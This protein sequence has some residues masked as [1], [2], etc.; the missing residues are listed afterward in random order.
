MKTILKDLK[1]FWVLDSRSNP[2]VEVWAWVE[3]NGK[4]FYDSFIVPSGASTGEFE[5]LELRDNTKDFHGKGVSKAINSVYFIRDHLINTFVDDLFLFD[6]KLIELDGSEN[7]SNLGANAIL[8]VS[9]SVAKALAKSYDLPFFKFLTLLTGIKDYFLPLPFMNVINGGVHADNDLDF[10]EFMICP[11]EFDTFSEA[12]KAGSEIYNTLKKI[13]KKDGFSVSVGDEGGFAPAF[14]DPFQACDYITKAIEESGYTNKVFLALDVAASSL[15]ENGKYKYKNSYIT[16]NDLMNIYEELINRYP[17]ISIEDPFAE[18]DWQSWQNFTNKY[19]NEINIV[20]DDLFVTNIKRLSKGID[21]G[22]ANS[23]LIKLNQIGTLTETINT[24]LKALE[25]GFTCI[26]SH[27]SGETEDNT[28]S[29]IACNIGY[30]IKTGAPARSERNA[31]YNELRRI[32]E[33][34]NVPFIK[35]K[36]L[37]KFTKRL[38]KSFKN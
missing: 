38:Q 11:M 2:T 20:G 23:I 29:S 22:A 27:R 16:S 18:E 32:E 35:N 3:R 34:Y 36:V 5:A 14:S 26:I 1:A 15:F 10:Q 28:I 9:V 21:I 17:I 24:V 13:L 19:K 4:V 33:F 6:Q 12:L 37:G 31:K 25:N 7:K 30:S 8:G